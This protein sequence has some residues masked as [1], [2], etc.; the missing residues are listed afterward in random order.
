MSKNKIL[1]NVVITTFLL[2]SLFV[3]PVS[4]TSSWSKPRP[5]DK[6]LYDEKIGSVKS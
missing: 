5:S 4:A 2:L 3:F 1:R 6:L